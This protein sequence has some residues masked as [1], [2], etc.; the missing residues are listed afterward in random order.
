MDAAAKEAALERYDR[1]LF[2][3]IQEKKQIT[4]DTKRVNLFELYKSVGL[5]VQ[6]ELCNIVVKTFNYFTT[7]P[8]LGE[9]HL[10]EVKYRIIGG[11]ACNLLIGAGIPSPDIDVEVAPIMVGGSPIPFFSGAGTIETIYGRYTEII[12]AVLRN[13]I[14]AS[15]LFENIIYNEDVTPLTPEDIAADLELPYATKT[16]SQGDMANKIHMALIINK[17][18]VS[19]I[20]AVIKYKG[21]V[22]HIIEIIFHKGPKLKAEFVPETADFSSSTK[23]I[24]LPSGDGIYIA[25]PN[26]LALQQMEALVGKK[27]RIIKKIEA[28]FQ[29][30]LNPSEEIIRTL[31][32]PTV[33]ELDTKVAITFM[34][35]YDIGRVL[36]QEQIQHVANI[37]C[38]KCIKALEFNRQKGFPPRKTIFQWMLP[39]LLQMS[40]GE[41][42]LTKALSEA[43]GG[44]LKLEEAPG[45]AARREQEAPGPAA[46]REQEEANAALARQLAQEVV[47]PPPIAKE[48]PL[49]IL[50]KEEKRKQK[51]QK[52]WEEAE[53]LTAAARQAQAAAEAQAAQAAA[54]QAAAAVPVAQ[55]KVEAPK[56]PKVKK[57][58]LLKGKVLEENLNALL[59][60]HTVP[61]APTPSA[62]TLPILVYPPIRDPLSPAEI[63]GLRDAEKAL[64]IPPLTVLVEPF[65]FKAP[66]I[67]DFEPPFKRDPAAHD[68]PLRSRRTLQTI[69]DFLDLRTIDPNYIFI[70][71]MPSFQSR[72]QLTKAGLEGTPRYMKED[73]E[74]YF[75]SIIIDKLRY[76]MYNDKLVKHMKKPVEIKEVARIEQLLK[77]FTDVLLTQL[78]QY[79]MLTEAQTTEVGGATAAAAPF[80]SQ[81][82][83]SPE[84]ELEA[85]ADLFIT[86]YRN[87]FV[88]IIEFL[89]FNLLQKNE[90]LFEPEAQ[91]YN[92]IRKDS[93]LKHMEK[94]WAKS[95][96]LETQLN[97]LKRE[98]EKLEQV[99]RTK[100]DAVYKLG[101]R[102][103]PADKKGAEDALEQ[104]RQK[105]LE[106]E[107]K[108]ESN[109]DKHTVLVEFWMA[110]YGVRIRV[111][112][113]RLNTL[114]ADLPEEKQPKN[115]YF[116]FTRYPVNSSYMS[117]NDTA[118]T[119]RNQ[120]LRKCHKM[121]IQ[122]NFLID[123]KESRIDAIKRDLLPED[124]EE[125]E[126]MFQGMAEAA[127]TDKENLFALNFNMCTI[128]DFFTQY[129]TGKPYYSDP[130]FKHA[131]SKAIL[132][133]IRA[134]RFHPH[135]F[136]N[137]Y[138]FL[139]GF[140]CIINDYEKG[141]PNILEQICEFI[142]MYYTSAMLSITT[143]EEK[144][145]SLVGEGGLIT[146]FNSAVL[147]IMKRGENHANATSNI[148]ADMLIL[149]DKL[150]WDP[151]IPYSLKGK[152]ILATN[153]FYGILTINTQGDPESDYIINPEAIIPVP[154]KAVSAG[155]GRFHKRTRRRR[156]HRKTRRGRRGR[157][158][159]LKSRRRV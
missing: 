8:M 30:M 107:K 71:T 60:E 44:P 72:Y 130:I 103:T 80:L 65:A 120:F 54:A 97:E 77:S 154:E 136:N 24:T 82:L 85:N 25:R 36:T 18:F 108:A 90:L 157:R 6:G 19:K 61:A 63:K 73:D 101:E 75:I 41:T 42:E 7:N 106:I 127:T 3:E 47:S 52:E 50:T 100:A 94:E 159:G 141:K 9:V 49:K 92:A 1:Q 139:P 137:N 83:T 62:V 26:I 12:F 131:L 70:Y 116:Y 84:A 35:I 17:G 114:L 22:Y 122:L 104:Y 138:K 102:A 89:T 34:R 76:I 135:Y 110:F 78:N 5:D 79:S 68:P 126:K 113:K 40:G 134:A 56:P 153:P 149:S 155:G 145:Q 55:Q 29:Y 74:I 66:L 4:L 96:Q 16:L 125:F 21:I 95:A 88:R 51:E 115:I 23:L 146:Q 111:L 98:A 132:S 14:V 118:A 11:N 48:L 140:E 33:K 109:T 46:R 64:V 112:K 93:L 53:L 27:G 67:E 15:K 10:P 31:W 152:P 57:K 129:F 39:G 143:E 151:L 142:H 144:Q 123:L 87:L 128:H 156:F 59:A 38:E 58:P 150:V 119:Y 99:V 147:D 13:S 69:I 91:Y 124:F 45:P 2:S 117:S 148:Y 133:T 43:V 81:F 121:K 105:G 86:F 28:E 158:V 37:I 32:E 20:Q